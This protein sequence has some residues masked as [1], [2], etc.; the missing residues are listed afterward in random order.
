MNDA[1]IGLVAAAAIIAQ[2]AHNG[3]TY[4]DQPFYNRHV[5]G[6]VNI[7]RQFTDDP[8]V[9]AVG[10]LHD[11]VEDSDITLDQLR[12][13]GFPEVVVEAVDLLTHRVDTAPYQRYICDIAY[14]LGEVGRIARLVK[15]AD[16]SF[17]LMNSLPDSNYHHLVPKYVQSLGMIVTVMGDMDL[18]WT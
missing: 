14:R 1:P 17:N 8:Q 2:A 4:Q 13:S 7:L 6:V 10:Y 11:V 18:R 9:L 12:Q 15:Y 5:V 16:L 3:Q